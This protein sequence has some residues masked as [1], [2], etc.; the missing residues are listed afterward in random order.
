MVKKLLIVTL[1]ALFFISCG[2]DKNN[3]EK[4]ASDDL[5]VP[6]SVEQKK[7]Q[8]LP[9]GALDNIVNSFSSPIEM[10]A[11]VKESGAQ[12]SKD[13]LSPI[14]SADKLNTEYEKAIG[15]G[16]LSSDLGY[17]NVYEQTSSIINLI[18]E[19]KR[20]ADDL[21]IGQFFD[22]ETLKDLAMSNTHLDSLMMV[23]TNSF[24]RMDQY[25]RNQNRSKVSTLMISG[26]WLEGMYFATQIVEES[27]HSD[28]REF[29]GNQKIISNDL[30]KILK[31][32][33]NDPNVAELLSQ[34][35]KLQK[36]YDNV[37]ITYTEG[38]PQ[39]KVESGRL[40]V[41]QKTQSKADMDDAT[42]K[43]IVKKTKE[44]RNKIIKL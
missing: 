23:S 44:I 13:Y 32:Y 25:L 40:V 26:V 8:K 43:Q 29:I 15:L 7:Q 16:V 22:F 34:L 39:T 41:V 27:G 35:K 2:S 14:E 12:F 9:Q 30:I 28:I 20:L 1:S 19:I 11:Y 5:S 33:K 18:G 21:R 10:A 38:E 42:L 37:E 31:V 4:S 6:D 17:L 3:K 24:N 36:V